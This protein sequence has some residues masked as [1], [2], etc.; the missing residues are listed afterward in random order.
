M[1]AREADLTF[2]PANLCSSN[3][4]LR[5]ILKSPQYT[6]PSIGHSIP[7]GAEMRL[8]AKHEAELAKHA[9]KHAANK[10]NLKAEAQRALEWATAHGPSP[11]N[12]S[13][14]SHNV[15]KHK[16]SSSLASSN[17]QV[18]GVMNYPRVND[19]RLDFSS[20]QSGGGYAPQYSG[21]EY[22]SQ[23]PGTPRHDRSSGYYFT[24]EVGQNNNDPSYSSRSGIPQYD[25]VWDD[26]EELIDLNFQGSNVQTTTSSG[27]TSGGTSKQAA[28]ASDSK[29]LTTHDFYTNNRRFPPG[30]E[31]SIALFFKR[32]R[33]KEDQAKKQKANSTSS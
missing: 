6:S 28:G 20:Y 29:R 3:N 26:M 2:S 10:E 4:F 18:H 25:G 24:T 13:V 19:G 23:V 11:S 31:A 21:M 17:L 15:R 14:T 8:R 30:Y 7:S 27:T 16:A 9:A 5:G 12:P 32:I 22:R 1:P 33:E